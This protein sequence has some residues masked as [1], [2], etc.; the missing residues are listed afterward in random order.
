MGTQN[1]RL[2][3]V[4][5]L[6]DSFEN[7]RLVLQAKLDAKK[8]IEER[9]KLGQFATPTS[10]ARDI[11]SFGIRNMETPH[12]IKFFDPAFGTG[13]FYSALLAETDINDISAAT[14]IEVDTLIAK[15][16]D[17]FWHDYNIN[18]IN[19]DFTDVEPDNYYNLIIC[20]P[21]YVRHHLIDIDS[22]S[23]IKCRTK[24]ISGVMLSGLA[25][26][27]CHFLLQSIQWMDEG[28]I[29]GWLIPSEFM[30][31][32]YGKD[33]KRFLLNEVEL[34]RIHRFNP[35]DVQ[36]GD[37]L[38]S[39]AVVW[40]RKRKPLIQNVMFTYGGTLNSPKESRNISADTLREEAKWT[41]F[42]CLPQRSEKAPAP[43]LKD[44]F[45]VRRGIATGGNDFFILEESRIA[46][47]GLPF[48]FFRPVL[49]SARHVQ[50]AEIESDEFGN[51]IL[52]Q[53]LFLLDCRLNEK[54]VRERYPRLWDYLESGRENVGSGYLCKS[55]KC[56]YFQEQRE[57]PILICTYMGRQ[58]AENSSAF[59]FIL[60]NSKATVTNSYLALYP[61]RNLSNS[62]A[63]NPNLKRDV[64]EMLNNI[65][66]DSLHSEG[67]VY[68]G[69]L[70]K[71]EPKE[72]LNVDVPFLENVVA[73]MEPARKVE[74]FVAHQISLF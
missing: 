55:R 33:M 46:E 16:T 62:F 24:K 68:G 51:P 28:A 12:D 66:P 73:P 70:Q 20:N 36:F 67:R 10:L 32:N 61:R 57:A 34:F 49:P 1:K 22:K 37:A 44:Y 19:A 13:A 7:Q 71:I 63:R 69:G 11:A 8:T 41:R 2:S 53:H 18:I 59:R 14:T 72:L 42:P 17:D 29:A 47:L 58:S 27:Y 6:G 26:L 54:E 31:V 30:D 48:E 23:R 74:T 15:A 52:P 38:V 60:N 56:W 25:G 35:N 43:K 50:I 39:S 21:P 45:D 3:P 64:W 5:P 9:R 40:F 4:W 65:T